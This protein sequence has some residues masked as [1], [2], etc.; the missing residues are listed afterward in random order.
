MDYVHVYQAPDTA[1]RYA[2][3]F[4]DNF[5]GWKQIFVPFAGFTRSAAQPAG[6]PN[7]GL[8]LTAVNGYGFRFPGATDQN[9]AGQATITAH[10]DQVQLETQIDTPTA[11]DVTDEPPAFMKAPMYL[12]LVVR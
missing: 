5:T 12:P 10:I 6:A 1:E 7:D 2:A 3:S 9:R 11:L 4:V 8:T